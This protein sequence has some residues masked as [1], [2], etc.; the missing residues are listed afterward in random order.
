MDTDPIVQQLRDFRRTRRITQSELAAR[1][2]TTQ[3]AISEY[4]QGVVSPTLRTLQNWAAALGV[5]LTAKPIRTR[6]KRVWG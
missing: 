4:E 3:P 2:G 5:T 6:S 1:M